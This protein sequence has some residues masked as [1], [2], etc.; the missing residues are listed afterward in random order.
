MA[1]SFHCRLV[2]KLPVTNVNNVDAKP[3]L[4]RQLYGTST[5]K[6]FLIPESGHPWLPACDRHMPAI[7]S[8]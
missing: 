4:E 3:P 2:S 6:V 7:G 8:K 1:V 5:A